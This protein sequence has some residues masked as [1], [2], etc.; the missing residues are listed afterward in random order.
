VA[1]PLPYCVTVKRSAD[2]GIGNF[3]NII[4]PTHAAK[5]IGRP[6][7]PPALSAPLASRADP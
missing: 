7:R 2:I 3:K 4:S 6:Q 1:R 5:L